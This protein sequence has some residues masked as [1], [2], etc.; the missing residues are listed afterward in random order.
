M[1]VLF[2]TY[3]VAF[4]CPGGGEIQLMECK[5][6]LESLGVKVF[7]YDQWN[8][9]LETFDAVHYF[10]VQGGSSNFCEFVKKKGLP[11]LISPILW[12]TSENISSFPM[13][14]ILSLL[15]LCDVVL[16]NAAAERDQLAL[17][18]DLDPEKCVVVPNGVSHSFRSLGRSDLF[19]EYLHLE[20]PF[21]LNVANIEPRKNQLTLVQAARGLGL[22]LVL[23]GRVRDAG[24]FEEC[25]RQGSQFVQ[26]GGV[27][28]HGGDLM[29]SA[30]RAAEVFVLPSLLETPGLAALEAATQEARL[31]ITSV[32]STREYF[33]G[34]VTYVD[35]NNPKDIRDGI[36]ATLT[37][38]SDESLRRQVLEKF[39]WDHAA[40]RLAEAY[41]RAIGA[42]PKQ[43]E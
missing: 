37:R 35:P 5:A 2:N 41:E 42:L 13:K 39:T 22:P 36:E 28:P 17:F 23:I 12:P 31:V 11:L 9:Q 1:R 33:Q 26:Y 24:Y 43:R 29:K 19:R 15:D 30:Y 6:A 8:P 34:L 40:V 16:P 27:L 7:L 4:D 21:L 38:K 3:P 32:G 14:E 10:S 25:M 18:F 20:G